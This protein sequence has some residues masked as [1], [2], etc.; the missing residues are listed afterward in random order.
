M[1]EASAPPGSGFDVVWGELP[2]GQLHHL[3]LDGEDRLTPRLTLNKGE[4]KIAEVWNSIPNVGYRARIRDVLNSIVAIDVLVDLAVAS[5][6][7]NDAED[8]EKAVEFKK[9]VMKTL[10]K[11]FRVPPELMSALD[12]AGES[13]GSFRAHSVVA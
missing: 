12:K 2:E 3:E 1:D 13:S 5:D 8:D 6:T 11:N 4:S 10:T 9:A 7:I